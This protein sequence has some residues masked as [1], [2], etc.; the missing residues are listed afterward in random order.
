ML[1]TVER[2][3]AD[4][5]LPMLPRKKHVQPAS[6]SQPFLAGSPMTALDQV[7]EV[8]EDEDDF[9]N[10]TLHAL[11]MLMEANVTQTYLDFFNFGRKA[12]DE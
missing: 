6:G 2:G 10:P 5:D 4:A 3:C 11:K 8:E 12:N 9:Y 1:A 7:E